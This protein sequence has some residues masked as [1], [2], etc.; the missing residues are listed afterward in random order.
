VQRETSVSHLVRGAKLAISGARPVAGAAGACG[1]MLLACS[2]FAIGPGRV[3]AAGNLRSP[4]P[5]RFDDGARPTAAKRS[6]LRAAAAG[7]TG[8]P[9]AT[10][11]RAAAPRTAPRVEVTSGRSSS[12]S[13]QAAPATPT[14]AAAP[15]PPP[16]PADAT[17]PAPVSAPPLPDGLPPVALPAVS[18]PQ[19]PDLPVVPTV[20]T[21]LGL[22]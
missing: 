6:H 17:T 3:D 21:S 10:R 20:T 8:H 7:Q 12:V 1:L 5:V 11:K 16:A 19:V 4:A 14:H 22:P 13:Q 15:A 18:V 2:W 9:R